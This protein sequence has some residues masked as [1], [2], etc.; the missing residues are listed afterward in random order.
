MPESEP[1]GK[2][3]GVMVM[4]TV[5]GIYDND[6]GCEERNPEESLKYYVVLKN[7]NGEEKEILAED[8]FLSERN[9]DVGST[10]PEEKDE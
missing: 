8:S 2:C 1:G 5:T 10:W 4:W 9:I 7:D 3:Y 6:Y